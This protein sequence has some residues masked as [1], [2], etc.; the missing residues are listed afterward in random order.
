MAKDSLYRDRNLQII[1]G[2]TLM[3]VLGVSSIT[4]AF[5]IMTRKLG[6][7]GDQVG[8]LITFFTLPGVILTPILG[9]LADRFGR[10]KILVPSLFLFA[11]AGTAC[12]FI[13][14]FNL[15]LGMR[16]IQGIG[17]A[18]LASIN[19]T[20]IGDLYSDKQRAEA[21]GLNTSALGIGTAIYPPLGGALA[22][23]GWNY[24]FALSIFAL[25]I[26]ILVLTRLKNPEPANFQGMSK[27]FRGT[28]SHLKNIKLAALF[29]TGMLFFIIM[30]GAYLTY[31][32]LYIDKTFGASSFVIGLI[33]F[34]SSITSSAVASQFGRISR[35]LSLS[36]IIKL[37][38][39]LFALSMFLIPF[40]P[41]L[42]MLLIPTLIFGT[43]SG[44]CLTTIQTAVASLVPLEHR[45]AIMSLNT[46][47]FNIGQ[48]IGPPL[49]ALVYVNNGPD[50]MFF[51]TAALA[52]TVPVA[53]TL[54]GRKSTRI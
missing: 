31:Y 42:L 1:F 30:S 16:V 54:F 13:S 17:G 39:C 19:T 24:P 28:W 36:T 4:P 18:S 5:P 38:F 6:I 33:L 15:L 20:I 51:A 45:A 50:T 40:M 34:C 41:V 53:A 23:L 32:P 14:N 3:A 37:V 29:I 21:M 2:V 49:M 22:L 26:G 48:A 7:T 25:P 12:T 46:T 10:K 9:A 52:L 43:G 8:L 35:W 27:Y 47:M 44:T 11:I